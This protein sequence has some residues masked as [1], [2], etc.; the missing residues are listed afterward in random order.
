MAQNLSLVLGLVLATA[1]LVVVQASPV[2]IPDLTKCQVASASS[3]AGPLVTLYFNCCLPLTGPMIDFSFERYKSPQKHIRRPA[4]TASEE[5]IAKYIKAYELMRALPDTDPRSLKVQANIH[6]S[7]CNG[8]YLQRG[9]NGDIP[10]QVHFSW[11]FLPWHR[12]YLYF[13]ERIL[14]SL[15]GDPGFSLLY[16]N[17][18][19]QVHGGNQI[20]EAFT[21]VNTSLYDEK[22]RPEVQP[23][24]IVPL[25]AST[26]ANLSAS[27]VTNE[28]LNNMYQSIVTA[29]T[30]TL[31]MGGA[32]RAGDDLRKSTVIN[33]PLGGAIEN[34]V[35][36]AIHFYVGDPRTQLL[37]DMGNFGTASRD[38]LFY[39]HHGNVDRLW[40]E[41][42]FNMPDG[43]RFDHTDPDFLNAEFVFY[44]E[45]ANMVRVKVKD[46]LDNKKLG[47]YYKKGLSDNRWINYSPPATTNE[48]AV[49][50]AV[51]SGV[52]F[53]GESPLN[54]TINIGTNFSAIVKRPS[55]KKPSKKLEVLNIQGVQVVRDEFV[56]LVAYVNLPGAGRGTPTDSAEYLG[57]FNIVPTSGQSRQL[58]TNVKYEIGDNLKRIGI[59]NE[60]EV[61]ISLVTTGSNATVTIEGLKIDYEDQ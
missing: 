9:V 60:E 12:W 33:A 22:R 57:T 44:D 5:Y 11:L 2:Q 41:W 46:A 53:V 45:N 21:R 26:P 7:F 31:F 38:P 61:V 8:G 49:A 10:L 51:A 4:H 20:P 29:S 16:W 13:H 40:E 34:G 18:D 52:P 17:W 1:L 3:P 6:C 58:F 37:Q 30:A 24:T 15:I 50:A 47:V 43:E 19:D 25:A 48:S 55:E 32:L 14:A 23:P 36:T 39:S 35:H 28:N 42:R 56:A 27:V 59:Q 54:G